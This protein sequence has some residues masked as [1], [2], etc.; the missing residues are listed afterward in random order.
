MLAAL[1][2]T[3]IANMQT[4]LTLGVV[5][6][7]ALGLAAQADPLPAAP[8]AAEQQPLLRLRYASFDPLAGEP[9]VPATMASRDDGRLFLV[10][11]A[12]AP[13]E[14][15]RQALM[16]IGA[17]IHTYMPDHS[18]VVR[19]P[20]SQ[21]KIA[22]ALPMIRWVGRYHP[23]YRIDPQLQPAIEA[24]GGDQARYHIVVVDKHQD[25][26][27]LAAGIQAIGGIVDNEQTGSL[28]FTVL[29]TPPQVLAAAHLDQVLW[30]DAWTAPEEDVDNARIQG[31][32]NYVESQAGY[33]G[34]GLNVHIY[35]GID[36][37]HP[38]YRGPVINVM[39]SGA[40]TGH[41]TNTAGIVFSDG[42]GN[43]QF[44]GFA[45]DTGKF[46][47]NY[48]SVTG[49]R[50]QVVQ[51]LINIRNVSHTTASWGGA[52]VLTYTS[53]SADADDIVFDHNITWTN[54]QSN[55]R[56]QM[57]RPEAW[58]KN[59]FSIGG[60]RHNN[61]SSPLD[62]SWAGGGASI[63]PASDGRIK[64][65]LAAYYESIG[66]TSSGGGYTTSFGGT[67]GATPIVAG[68]NALAIQM[69]TDDSATPGV[70]PFGNVLRAPQEPAATFIHANRPHF[71]TLK[72]LQVISAYQ[73]PF[74][75]SSTDNRREHL[76][77]GYPSLQTM[78]DL[79]TKTL[80]IDET[81]VLQ[82]GQTHRYEVSVTA[83]EPAFRAVLNYNEPAG[84]PAASQQLI[85]NL[86]LR[87][88][89]PNN[90]VYWGNHGLNQGNW[91]PPGGSEDVINPIECVF[92]QNPVAGQWVIEVLGTLIV[93]D[94]HVETPVV[95]ADYGL[96]VTGGTPAPP[97]GAAF[98][99]FGQ[100]CPGST[101]TVTPCTTLNGTGGTLTGVA[102]NLEYGMLPP[103]SNALTVTSAEIWLRS[104]GGTV[105]VPVHIYPVLGTVPMA[106]TTITVGPTE[107]F[108]TA[109]FATPVP[110]AVSYLLAVDGSAGNL[111]VPNLTA[112]AT[113]V[114]F[115]RSASS[116][117]TFD[118]TLARP[119][120]R[121]HC[122]AGTVFDVPVLGNNGLPVLG[123]SYSI[124][125]ADA[126]PLSGAFLL[127]GFSDA[128][129]GAT[130]LPAPL[131][132]A[133]GCQ[134]LVSAESS[135][136]QFTSATGT[137]AGSFTMPNNPGLIGVQLFHQW[138]VLDLSVNPLGLVVS[139]GG[140]A[141]LGT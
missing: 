17:T 76:G 134:L 84:N 5:F 28:L 92:V 139:D 60:F 51:E 66:T 120:F 57:S 125:L 53:V 48:S 41:G 49:S 115:T 69:F 26:P 93:Q 62:D 68:H 130:P 21:A 56:T 2:L 95:D 108:Y 86:S 38:A 131:P 82:Q 109:T 70:G 96:V 74:N 58:A 97:T 99:T 137:A 119:S 141:R 129:L 39:S 113:S 126:L 61:N 42:T 85:N 20:E 88:T 106:S 1:P 9:A 33:T 13:T 35:E 132:G 81:E 67:S 116:G 44:R 50:W 52:R 104:T 22:R 103:F 114:V 111:V 135:T 55:A 8:A 64:P 4:L 40:A 110:L 46:Y 100:G 25:K 59:V 98:R 122:T 31:G 43:P 138:A 91:S 78:W 102:G 124:T 123:N 15:G 30:I 63:G 94:N 10:Q 80:I 34:T 19:M 121:V 73:Y 29:L 12:G 3:P 6:G 72:A 65:D 128:I 16:A 117:W 47:T 87:V 37:N 71:T 24:G 118:P 77:W 7:C 32:A 105:T 90:T 11:F 83:G 112:G 14:A 23:A 101:N 27:A 140:A 133:P 127:T 107:G 136:L 89:S 18:Y 79:R 75:A 36:A 54:S 45:P